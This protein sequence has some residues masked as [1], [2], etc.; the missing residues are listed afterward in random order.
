[1]GGEAFRTALG[2]LMEWAAGAPTAVMCAE[3]SPADCHRGLLCDAL[4]ASGV[5]A[6]HILAPGRTLEHA[7]T[8]N[9]R[10]DGSRVIYDV[11]ML[12]FGR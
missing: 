9:A 8:A 6:V 5:K 11:G 2:E 4:L 10:V 12:P 1:M 7:L 3:A